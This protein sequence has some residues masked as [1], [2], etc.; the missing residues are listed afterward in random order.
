MT[1]Y[2]EALQP[3]IDKLPSEQKE[4]A[5]NFLNNCFSEFGRILNP[6][7]P[8]QIDTLFC[9]A[10]IEKANNR[11]MPRKGNLSL[12][13]FAQSMFSLMSLYAKQ[14]STSRLTNDEILRVFNPIYVAS[15]VYPLANIA[16]KEQL[17]KLKQWEIEWLRRLNYKLEIDYQAF[18]NLLSGVNGIPED[19]TAHLNR[20]AAFKLLDTPSK[21]SVSKLGSESLGILTSTGAGAAIGAVIGSI[22]PGIGTVIGAILGAGI[23]AGVSSSGVGLKRLW[24]SHIKSGAAITSAGSTSLGLTIGIIVGSVVFPGLG[25]VLGGGIGAV[26]GFL[27]SIIPSAIKKLVHRAKTAKKEAERSDSIEKLNITEP[28]SAD[29][30]SPDLPKADYYHRQIV[31]SPP[32]E[33][34]IKVLMVQAQN[35][36]IDL[37]RTLEF[38][39]SE[40]KNKNA[41]DQEKFTTALD[42]KDIETI[43]AMLPKEVEKAPNIETR[44]SLADYLMIA[45]ELHKLS[46]LTET[47]IPSRDEQGQPTNLLYY[48]VA[49]Q[50]GGV[51][52]KVPLISEDALRNKLT[53]L[54][55][56]NIANVTDYIND[57]SEYQL[58]PNAIIKLPKSSKI[59]FE[60]EMIEEVQHELVALAMSKILDCKTTDVAMVMYEEKPALFIPFEEIKLLGEVAEGKVFTGMGNTYEHY[61]TIK[62][63]GSGLQ[64][65]GFI[66]DFGKAFSLLYVCSD[67]DSIGAYNQNKALVNDRSL[68]IFD[69]VVMLSN[70]LKLDSRLSLQPDQAIMKHTRHGRGRNRSLIEDSSLKEKF[71]SLEKLIQKQD[72]IYTYLYNIVKAHEAQI[73]QIN[74]SLKTKSNL[75]DSDKEEIDKLREQKEQVTQLRDD[76]IALFNTIK[77]RIA[78]IQAV[79]P[80]V[81][82]DLPRSAVCSAL[83]LE[84]LMHNPRLYTD[85]GKPYRNPWTYRHNNPVQRVFT[86]GDH[87]VVNFTNNIPTKMVELLNRN[88][89]LL[90]TIDPENPKSL[91]MT[92]ADFD[93]LKEDMLYPEMRLELQKDTNYLDVTS[94]E[95]IGKAYGAGHQ[96]D[97]LLLIKKYQEEMNSS[98][99]TPTSKLD[100]MCT[101]DTALQVHAKNADDKGFAMHVRKKLQFDI[102]Q[103]LLAIIPE[104]LKARLS[105]QMKAA[106][107]AALRLDQGDVFNNVVMSVIRKNKMD[108]QEFSNFLQLCID[109]A[110]TANNHQS[111]INA[112]AKISKKA[113]KLGEFCAAAREEQALDI[114]VDIN[115]D[116]VQARKVELNAQYQIID[117]TTAPCLGKED[118]FVEE[119]FNPAPSTI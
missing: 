30:S 86:Q 24:D 104:D 112:R 92:R 55:D 40:D 80:L 81:S 64:S 71:A 1:W 101:L 90:I 10:V 99:A 119:P 72:V 58:K 41:E 96:K 18:K 22:V 54:R 103:R 27:A 63:I 88:R 73:S 87:V 116:P 12:E 85:T 44:N 7:K 67:P 33:G 94:L 51:T 75:E 68:F 29:L 21:S 60:G 31:T 35:K 82:K 28:D 110:T 4:K 56:K 8:N 93:S 46:H 50:V 43:V 34:D 77:N 14:R 106:F 37:L 3:V 11:L 6:E 13:K 105:D 97:I 16:Q 9:L 49:T 100:A 25:T 115:F 118:I 23:G 95:I 111:A 117:K 76:A 36:L 78:E 20:K 15:D 109:Q 59:P 108:S 107:V 102:Q 53:K 42:S 61:S 39:G 89:Q 52:K 84:K 83:I 45:S 69:Q 32:Q 48:T 38:K 19:I 17:Q 57:Y 47:Q 113:N 66:D 74:A 98:N 91:T 65:N 26:T 70:K 114:V 5:K 79:L 62:P 2:I